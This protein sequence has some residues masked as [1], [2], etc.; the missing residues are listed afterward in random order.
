MSA[1]RRSAPLIVLALMAGAT[2]RAVPVTPGAPPT[3]LPGTT[4]LADPALAGVVLAD[5]VSP[6]ASADDPMYGFPGAEGQLQSRVVRETASGTLDFYWRLSVNPASYPGF[7]PTALVIDGLSPALL[8]TGAVF[9]ADYRSD[10]SGDAAPSGASA[11]DDALT[12]LF[13]PSTFGPGSSSFL[14]LLRSA[15]TS[16][17]ASALAR[18]GVSSPAT[19]APSAV[20]EPAGA[21][22]LLAGL[23]ALGAFA[24]RARRPR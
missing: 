16:Y 7:V 22:L 21:A 9:D 17:D 20:P 12:W 8:Q 15:A 3:T 13:D 10:G 11:T 1:A 2:A 6:W 18:V 14:L 5:V 23:G 4:A 19:F 24:A